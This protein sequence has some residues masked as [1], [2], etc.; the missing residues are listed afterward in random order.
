MP[1]VE[2][3]YAKHQNNPGLP[4]EVFKEKEGKKAGYTLVS[5]LVGIL[6]ILLIA[7]IFF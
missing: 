5:V 2:T 6:I 4:K 7:W 3:D 1:K